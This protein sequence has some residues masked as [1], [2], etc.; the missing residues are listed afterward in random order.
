[1]SDWYSIVYIVV[2]SLGAINIIIIKSRLRRQYPELHD[3]FF[4]KTLLEMSPA[5]S[6]RFLKYTFRP[7][8]WGFLDDKTKC[9]FLANI[10]WV[11][12]FLMVFLSVFFF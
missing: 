11:I 9:Y 1:M 6:I 12:S 7:S 3:S 8:G 5:H 10:V 4:G 2:W